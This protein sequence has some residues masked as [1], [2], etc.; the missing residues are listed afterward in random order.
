MSSEIL[1]FVCV[2]VMAEMWHPGASLA[3]ALE[4]MS[5]DD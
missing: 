3:Y 1:A 4:A 2:V 5:S